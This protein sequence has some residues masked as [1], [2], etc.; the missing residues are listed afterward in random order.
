M[1]KVVVS[2]IIIDLGVMDI[3]VEGMKLVELVCDVNLE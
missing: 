2:C 1:G 3:I